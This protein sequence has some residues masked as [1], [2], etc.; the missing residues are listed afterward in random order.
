MR[1]RMKEIEEGNNE[2]NDKKT[3]MIIILHF[4]VEID[5]CNDKFY[6]ESFFCRS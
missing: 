6:I 1:E 3:V 4:T 5:T 2:R